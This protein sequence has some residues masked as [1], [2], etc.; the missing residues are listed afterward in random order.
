VTE[1]ADADI[2]VIQPR[3]AGPSIWAVIQKWVL[4]L[5]AGTAEQRARRLSLQAELQ[6]V[7]DMLDD[8]KGIGEDGVSHKLIE[9][10]NLD[11]DLDLW[12]ISRRYHSLSSR[13][14]ISSARTSLSFRTK[15]TP[16]SP[17]TVSL[18]L[19]SSITNTPFLRLLLSTSQIISLSGVAMTA[20]T[21]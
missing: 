8:G 17:K 11:L 7:V 15:T 12:L 5:P 13:M 4:A 6:W 2:T 19:T 14:A 3:H 16:R 9:F 1:I 18:L 20:T 21:T 10:L